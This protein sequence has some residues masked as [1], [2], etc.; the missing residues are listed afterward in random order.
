MDAQERRDEI[1]Q[2]WE[3]VNADIKAGKSLVREDDARPIC[4]IHRLTWPPCLETEQRFSEAARDVS[5]WGH[6]QTF[7]SICI[8]SLLA[9]S[10]CP[11]FSSSSTA[12]CTPSRKVLSRAVSIGSVPGSQASR[13]FRAFVRQPSRNRLRGSSE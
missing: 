13:A 7:R 11:S 12:N 8:R 2:L 1:T 4:Q 6:S 5:A 9:S 3:M 10:R